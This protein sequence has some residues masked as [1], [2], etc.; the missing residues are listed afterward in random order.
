VASVGTVLAAVGLYSPAA[1]A[2]ALYYGAH[3]TLITA[4]LFLLADLLATQRGA[5]GDRL[6]PAAPVAQPALLGLLLLLAAAAAA[7][8]P[9]LPGFIG[10]LMLLQAAAG[11]PG[12]VAVWAVVLG[13]GLLTLVALARSGSLLFWQLRPETPVAAASADGRGLAATVLLIGASVAMSVTAAPLLRYAQ[14]AAQQLGDRAAYADA[15]LPELGG[16]AARSTRPY[17]GEA[18]PAGAAR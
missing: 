17:T 4:G 7:G 14:A 10:K 6:E 11:A 13:M 8:L 12:G 2:A 16:A 3:S 5:A 9:P 15:V 1:W 18:P